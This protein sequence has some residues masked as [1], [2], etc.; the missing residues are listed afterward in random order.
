[1]TDG[2]YTLVME[3]ESQKMTREEW[4]KFQP[5]F[6]TFF[7]PGIFTSLTTTEQGMDVAL[8]SDGSGRGRGGGDKK[9]VLPP[10]MPGLPA[11]EL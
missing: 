3:F 10:L 11:R 8:I 5:K 9:D 2:A 7:G 6:D 1:M 4:E